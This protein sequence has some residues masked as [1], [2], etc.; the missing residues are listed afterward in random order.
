MRQNSESPW[1]LRTATTES[2]RKQTVF[3]HY[4]SILVFFTAGN[5]TEAKAVAQDLFLAEFLGHRH[6]D[7]RGEGR[8]GAAKH[9]NSFSVIR[10]KGLNSS[11]LF[12]KLCA[13]YPQQSSHNKNGR[14]LGRESRYCSRVSDPRLGFVNAKAHR[15][16]YFHPLIADAGSCCS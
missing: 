5:I 6:S 1:G 2:S 10:Q 13:Q 7:K 16:N 4:N 11:C 14:A 12:K 3:L 15:N 9:R 8:G